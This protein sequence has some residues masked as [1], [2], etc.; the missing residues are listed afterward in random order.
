MNMA[1]IKES[2]TPTVDA[3][4]SLRENATS[5][6]N[7]NS[8]MCPVP[9]QGVLKG[10]NTGFAVAILRD[11]PE[12]NQMTTER[13]EGKFRREIGS[14]L[15]R[16]MTKARFA[17]LLGVRNPPRQGESTMK[18]AKGQMD[19]D[20]RADRWLVENMN[21]SEEME[22]FV[23]EIPDPFGRG[24]ERNIW[25]GVMGDDRSTSL[26]NF[27]VQP[28][29][30]LPPSARERSTVYKLCIFVRN[31]FE[32]ESEGD[33][34][35]SKVQRTRMRGCIETA[36]SLVC[37]EGVKLDSFGQVGEVLS[38]VGEKE[39]TNGPSTRLNPSFTVRWTCLS[40]VAIKQMIKDS[41]LQGMAKF[42]L[43]GISLFQ[44]YSIGQEDTE[45][46]SLRSAQ[47]MDNDASAVVL[48][49]ESWY[50]NQ[51]GTVSEIRDILRNHEESN[52]M[53]ERIATEAVGSE[54]IDWRIRLLQETMDEVTHK[55]MRRLPGVFFDEV[56]PSA[57]NMT[58]EA[59]D[60]P[61]FQT[62]PI[63]SQLIF[64]GQQLQRICTLYQ[65]LRY[66]MER[67]NTEWDE[68]AL[69]NLPSLREF[70]IS[71][72]GLK[73]L[74]ERQLWRLRDL[75]DGGGLGFTIELFFLALRQLLATS[76][77]LDTSRLPELTKKFYARTFKVIESNGAEGKNSPG[78]Q[79]IL[80]DI[81]CDLV[82][83]GRGIFS[84]FTYPQSI[85]E[86]L[87]DLLRRVVKGKNGPHIDKVFKELRDKERNCTDIG[88]HLRRK[89]LAEFCPFS[90]SAHS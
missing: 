43:D 83:K 87:L 59:F 56:Q 13:K 20:V 67:Q 75:R 26:S 9:P 72:I 78:T 49:L 27:Q 24:W 82:I 36:A 17:S 61:S 4:N 29:S 7:R 22:A 34:M 86:M 70:P 77:S 41:R 40:L 63:P 80:L 6:L 37:C 18:P 48:G 15:L 10:L 44:T 58:S 62:T 84:D 51:N 79:R 53:L 21:D 46:A 69:K 47:R 38:K 2:I 5:L 14:D 65:R 19:L 1:R 35:A 89:V 8:R 73:H 30:G 42:A 81:L 39:Q 16:R 54:G 28:H 76:S 25:M 12:T 50:W 52:K 71:S 31:F 64:P 45:T 57:P 3:E 88:I 33:F 90:N 85:V 11:P 55:L 32:T 23:L 60:L 66:I 68:D 74:M